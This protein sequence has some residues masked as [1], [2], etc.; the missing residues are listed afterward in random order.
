V[1]AWLVFHFGF[2][3]SGLKGAPFYAEALDPKGLFPAWNVLAFVVTT[4]TVILWF[5]LMDFWPTTTLAAALPF[6]SRQP[7]FGLISAALVLAI[8]WGMWTFFISLLGMDVVDYLVRVAVSGLFGEFILLV[9]MQTAPFQSLT[10]P[11][12][13]VVMLPVIAV[14]AVAMYTLYKGAALALVGPM[15]AGA[16]AY[17]LDLWIATAMLSVTFPIFV[18]LGDGFAFWPLSRQALRPATA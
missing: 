10:Q 14:L 1:A 16:P 12:K 8:S 9:M 6:L 13:G 7:L 2:D 4:V 17:Q 18:A 11:L 5:V 3:F 15:P